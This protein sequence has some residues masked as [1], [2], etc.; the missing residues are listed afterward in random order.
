MDQIDD[1]NVSKKLNNIN[2]L[3]VFRFSKK[4]RLSS[5]EP[6]SFIIVVKPYLGPL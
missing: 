2:F 3:P 6:A 5:N 4:K 1:L